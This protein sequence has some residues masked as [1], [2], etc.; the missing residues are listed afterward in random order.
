[1]QLNQL[2]SL[3]TEE[4]GRQVWQFDLPIR[5]G[6]ELDSFRIRLEQEESGN[7]GKDADHIWRATL[8]FDLAPLGPMQAQISLAEEHVSASFLA[9]RME[10]AKLLQESLPK[11]DASFQHAGLKVG[12][13]SAQ[14][15]R[16]AAAEPEHRPPKPLLDEKA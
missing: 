9:E 15:S 8:N 2:A 1:V 5:L 4:G 13:L 7:N 3:P 10:S 14:Q 16:K 11:L 12:R 6:E